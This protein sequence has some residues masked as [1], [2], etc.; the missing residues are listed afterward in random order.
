M[1]VL[2]LH[3]K[4]LSPFIARTSLGARSS[5]FARLP[6]WHFF[7]FFAPAQGVFQKFRFSVVVASL[8]FDDIPMKEK[9][10][11]ILRYVNATGKQ[12]CKKTS[13]RGNAGVESPRQ[14]V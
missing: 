2:I 6:R 10:I 1:F 11:S 14:P 7:I 8:C 4:P 12:L 13:Q 5:R 3:S 9:E